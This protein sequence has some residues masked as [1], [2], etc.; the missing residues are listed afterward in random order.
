VNF[1]GTAGE[2]DVIFFNQTF[3]ISYWHL[4]EKIEL[5]I[6]GVGAI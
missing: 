2:E 5:L 6:G 3:R 4:V 1:C